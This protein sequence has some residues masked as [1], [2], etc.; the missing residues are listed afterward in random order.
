M[1]GKSIGYNFSP[2]LVC[3]DSKEENN[4]EALA[5]LTNKKGYLEKTGV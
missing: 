3:S 2:L 4:I 1:L 5:G